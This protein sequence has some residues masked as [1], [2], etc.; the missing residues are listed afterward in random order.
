MHTVHTMAPVVKRFFRW[1]ATKNGRRC[2]PGSP[3][4][5]DRRA[6]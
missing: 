1:T 4:G 3:Q 5:G 6:L 2:Q